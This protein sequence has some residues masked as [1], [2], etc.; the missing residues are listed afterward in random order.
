MRASGAPWNVGALP[1]GPFQTFVWN[2][3][4]DKAVYTAVPSEPIATAGSLLPLSCNKTLVVKDIVPELAGPG[5][6]ALTDE[7]SIESETA[8]TNIAINA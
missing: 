8:M 3:R 7:A 5:F 4:H 6:A 2:N 1:N